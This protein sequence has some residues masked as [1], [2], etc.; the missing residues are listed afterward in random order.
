MYNKKDCEQPAPHPEQQPEYTAAL[1]IESLQDIFASCG[2]YECRPINFGLGGKII[3]Y[4]CWLDG[5]ISGGDVSKDVLRPLTMASRAESITNERDCI[6]QIQLGAVYS[7]SVK[8]REVIDD[9]ISDLT[10]GR[11]AI[12]FPR[13]NTALTFELRSPMVRSISQPTLEKSLK[14]AKD[15]FVE[16]LR[17]NTALVRR[18]LATPKL[19]SVESTVGRKSKTCVSMMFVDGIANPETVAELA[20]RLDNM[21]VDAILSMGKLEEFL[22]DVPLSP[23]PQLLHTER[24]DRFS[25]YLA[26]GRVGL[27]IDGMSVGLVLPATL[28][29]FMQVP[30]DINMHYTSA[31]ALTIIRYTAMILALFLPGLYVAIAMYHHEMIPTQLLLSIIAAE[32]NV[33]FSPAAEI[34][35]MVISFGLLQEAGLRM[36][37]PIGGTI[38]IIGALI[39]GQSAVEAQIVSSISIIIVAFSSISCYALPNQDVALTVRQLRFV[40][41]LAAIFAG[42]FGVILFSCLI[43]L[44]LA[45]IDNFGINYTAPLSDGR[46]GGLLRLLLRIP[47]TKN[48]FR[49]PIL[50]TPDKR[51]QK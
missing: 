30:S 13:E 35:C 19:K 42:L 2:D 24:P 51:R 31:T 43:L 39:V 45:S 5:I 8:R 44:H 14:G 49:D 28:A 27:L 26:D 10:H 47:K 1:S 12:I 11:C 17:V 9:V 37:D 38:S 21:E 16:S 3:L 50:R 29:E 23:F 32:Q 33:P 20:R 40:L 18:R 46:P 6:D 22:V 48:K 15:S 4:V 34:I 36:P 41:L 25:T 7:H